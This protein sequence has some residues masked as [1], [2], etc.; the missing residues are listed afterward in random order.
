M[1]KGAILDSI[2]EQLFKI[3]G[4]QERPE[5]VKGIGDLF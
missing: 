4:V 5:N 3:L 2:K 1:E